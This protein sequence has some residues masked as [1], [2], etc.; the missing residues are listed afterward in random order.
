MTTTTLNV[1]QIVENARAVEAVSKLTWLRVP[2]AAIY[3]NISLTRMWYLV[4]NKIIPSSK[5]G[6]NV[7][8]HRPDLDKYWAAHRR[9]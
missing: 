9:V 5:D 4:H 7:V 3:A 1:D 8:I 2:E 6:R